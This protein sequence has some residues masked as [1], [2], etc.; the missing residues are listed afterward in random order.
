MHKPILHACLVSLLYQFN[1]SGKR[2]KRIV[3]F[4]LRIKIALLFNKTDVSVGHIYKI[5]IEYLIQ[6]RKNM[7]ISTG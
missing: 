3:H 5:Y 7:D 6:P 2:K 4:I 1:Q